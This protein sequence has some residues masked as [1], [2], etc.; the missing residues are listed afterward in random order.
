MSLDEAVLNS[1]EFK[2][3][4]AEAAKKAISEQHQG[5]LDKRDELLGSLRTTKDEL[6]TLKQ[7]NKDAD[8]AVERQRLKTLQEEG[9]FEELL[10][11]KEKTYKEQLDAKDARYSTLYDELKKTKVD[12]KL[13]DAI[14][15]AK[16]V[17]ELLK[18]HM[19][20]RV[21]MDENFHVQV[22]KPNGEPM[23]NQNGDYASVTDLVNEYKQDPIYGRA[24][25]ANT[26]SGTGA[27]GGERVGG[28][29]G[30]GTNP[31]EMVKDPE[32]GKESRRNI[33]EGMRLYKE[34]PEKARRMAEEVGFK[35]D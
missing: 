5:L 29:D 18:P 8:D 17:P 9:K 26:Q 22:L 19:S 6:E 34:N 12:A 28:G 23:L 2:D 7:K 1:Q 35:L 10:K 27:R 11:A 14:A 25:E 21:K 15:S 20:V 24:F 4:V 3:A 33:T 13:S 16:G 31:F 32:T 30:K